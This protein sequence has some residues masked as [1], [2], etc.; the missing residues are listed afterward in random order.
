MIP[1]VSPSFPWLQAMPAKAMSA[2]FTRHVHTSA[3]FFYALLTF[4]A[5]FSVRNN[6]F[7]VFRFG[8]VL[9]LPRLQKL[10]CQQYMIIFPATETKISSTARASDCNIIISVPFLQY[11][12]LAARKWTPTHCG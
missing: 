2:H 3:V 8:V 4:G 7:E 5:F 12:L 10:T 1:S 11:N 9:K 6:P